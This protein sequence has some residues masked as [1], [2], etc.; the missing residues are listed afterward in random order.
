MLAPLLLAAVLQDPPAPAPAAEPLVVAHRGAS[1]LLPEHTLE[2]VAAAHALGADYLEA[3]AVLTSDGVP[4]V[5]HDIYLDATT[6]V[7]AVFP[8]RAVPGAP[9]G[10]RFRVFDFSLEEVKRLKARERVDPATGRPVFPRRFPVGAAAFEVPT[11]AEE[12]ALV[13]G[14]NRSARRGPGAGAGVMVELKDPAAHRAAGLDLAPAV[15][16]VLGAAGYEDRGDRCYVQCFDIAELRRVR[17]ELGSDLKLLRLTRAGERL[18]DEDLAAT[19]ELCAAVGPPL[20][21][22]LRFRNYLYESTGL[23]ERAAAAGLAVFPYTARADALPAAAQDAAG[24][25]ILH[26]AAL[27]A[28]AAGL[29]TDHP[30]RTAAAFARYRA[31]FGR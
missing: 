4:V 9:P 27:G 24:F 12:L 6:N 26:E 28:G 25:Y 20:R 15:L 21:D 16:R 30:G 14:L 3:D 2:A 13:R 5:L 29:F 31:R 11:L 23:I 17:G 8:G 7:A 19:A 10:R 1:G 22:C 18:T